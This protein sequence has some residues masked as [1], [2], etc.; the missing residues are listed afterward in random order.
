MN[1]FVEKS[2]IASMNKLTAVFLWLLAAATTLSAAEDRRERVLNDRKEV[3]AAGHWIYNDLPRGFA[4]AA[5]TGK[6]LLIVVRCVP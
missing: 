1:Q 5:R 2:S 6:P 3:E 4:E